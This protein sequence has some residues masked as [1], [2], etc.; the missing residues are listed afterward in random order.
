MSCRWSLVLA[1]CALCAGV[2]AEVVANRPEIK[3]GDTWVYQVTYTGQHTREPRL[4]KKKVADV[5]DGEIVLAGKRGRRLDLSLN[6]VPG[7]GED[8]RRLLLQFP[9]EKNSEWSYERKVNSRVRPVESG[10]FRVVAYERLTVPAGTFDCFKITGDI[11]SDARYSGKHTLQEKWYCPDIKQIAKEIEET[12]T[13]RAS[14]PGS[15]DVKTTEL[16]RFSI[17]RTDEVTSEPDD[18]DDDSFED[19]VPAEPALGVQR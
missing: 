11:R 16:V 15:R 14:G 13:R 9:L 12:R 19:A 6:P 8:F 2:E 10:V 18:D 17:D 5:V 1:L 3:R 4:S 7:N